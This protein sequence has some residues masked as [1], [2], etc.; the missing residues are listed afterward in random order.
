MT[1]TVI[2]VERAVMN[3]TVKAVRYSSQEDLNRGFRLT[4]IVVE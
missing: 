4:V 1:L 3:R 2:Q